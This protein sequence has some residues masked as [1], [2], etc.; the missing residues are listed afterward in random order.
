MNEKKTIFIGSIIAYLTVFIEILLS[1]FFTPFLLKQLGDIDYGIRAFCNSLVSY[2]NLL[3]LGISGAY[4][5]FRK[6]TENQCPEKVKRLNGLF[7]FC[8]LI[9][10]SVALIL[11]LIFILLLNNGVIQFE[12]FPVERYRAIN[13]VLLI[14]IVQTTIHFPFAI[15]TIIITYRRRFIFRN[16]STLVNVLLFPLLTIILIISG[17]QGDLLIMVVIV[18]F[19]TS[20][21]VDVFKTLYIFLNLKEKIA[22]NLKREDFKL[23]KPILSFCVVMFVSTAVSIIHNATDQVILGVSISAVTVTLYSLAVSFSSYLTTATTT[24][25]GLLGPKITNDSIDN[26]METVQKTCDFVWNI[27]TIILCLIIG[28]FATCGKEFVS[29]WV[30]DA[31]I[32]VYYYALAL[33]TINILATGVNLSYTIHTALNKHKFAAIVYISSLCFNILFSF[34]LC[35]YIGVWGVIVPTIVAKI[36]EAIALTYY[37]KRII[38]IRMNEYWIPLL[39]NMAISALCFFT[40]FAIFKAIDISQLGYY[41]QA[42]IKGFSFLV[43]FSISIFFRRKKLIVQ[44]FKLIKNKN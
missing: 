39:E 44:C 27:I 19:I 9:I 21:L 7:V 30:G 34:I 15:T 38:K 33:F 22:L 3:T 42:V 4:F 35:R 1:I 18:S 31:K 43:L 36:F 25:S 41:L 12:K 24:I 20:I 11:G 13:I 8:F 23:L 10:A 32:E 6:L 14:M 29:G 40:I 17:I 5:R 28:G 16:I 26:K 37:T 2:L